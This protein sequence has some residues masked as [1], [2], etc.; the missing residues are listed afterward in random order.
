MNRLNAFCDTPAT[1]AE[2]LHKSFV[3]RQG[4]VLVICPSRS[5][6][7][8]TL[9]VIREQVAQELRGG[10]PLVVLDLCDTQFI[11]GAGLEWVL[12]LDESCGQRGGAVRLCNAGEVCQ[13]ILRITRAG[14]RLDQFDSLIE[15]L[16]SFS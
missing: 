2:E 14:E 1:S 12:D 6:V 15:S 16:R 10:I 8:E 7:R 3:A 5:L 11:D 13:D 9:D 4:A